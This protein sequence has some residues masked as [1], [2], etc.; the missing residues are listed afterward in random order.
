MY[1]QVK[2][3]HN[4]TVAK[5]LCLHAEGQWL[6]ENS[7]KENR[8]NEKFLSNVWE[9]EN[10]QEMGLRF[11]LRPSPVSYTHLPPPTNWPQPQ[12]NYFQKGQVCK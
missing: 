9:P 1:Y 2:F 10:N 11:Y 7:R 3:R 6:V 12:F 5:P 4:S 8:E